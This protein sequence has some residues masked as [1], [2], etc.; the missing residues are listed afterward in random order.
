MAQAYEFLNYIHSK[1]GS[2][3][4]AEGSGYNPG[5]KDATP[6]LSDKAK[7][8]FSEAYPGDCLEEHVVAPGRADLVRRS[9]HP[10]RRE[11]QGCVTNQQLSANAVC[12]R[13]GGRVAFRTTTNSMKAVR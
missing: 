3:A 11:V 8:I 7:A 13:P 4:V 9:A 6:L 10:V 5:N 1:E 12:C 2:A